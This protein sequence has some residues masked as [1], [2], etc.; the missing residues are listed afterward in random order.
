M[1]GP[2]RI[3]NCLMTR[4]ELLWNNARTLIK[5]NVASGGII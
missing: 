3:H 4:V 5:Y 1:G 2:A